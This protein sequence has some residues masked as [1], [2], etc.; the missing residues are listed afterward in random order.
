MQNDLPKREKYQD[1]IFQCFV[2]LSFRTQTVTLQVD[3]QTNKTF[4]A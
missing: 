4:Y 2:L 1:Q 3:K